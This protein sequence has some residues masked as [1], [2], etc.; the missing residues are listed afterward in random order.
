MAT[1]EEKIKKIN[2]ELEK[3]SD[4]ELDAVVGGNWLDK[5]IEKTRL[6]EVM[7]NQRNKNTARPNNK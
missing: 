5:I 3:L 1:R 7:N 2:D 6:I 4:E